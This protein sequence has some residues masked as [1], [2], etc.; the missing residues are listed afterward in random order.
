[1]LADVD[2]VEDILD[3]VGF[4][5][6]FNDYIIKL[7]PGGSWDIL[8]RKVKVLSKDLEQWVELELL[9][10]LWRTLSLKVSWLWG[11]PWTGLAPKL[12]VVN[13]TIISWRI[14]YTLCSGSWGVLL[15]RP[16]KTVTVLH[17]IKGLSK[18]LSLGQPGQRWSEGLEG[19]CSGV[20][21]LTE[22]AR[23]KALGHPIKVDLM[24]SGSP[25][26]S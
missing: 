9:Y 26:C 20:W 16:R 3:W 23:D 12:S 17:G 10:V 24:T 25:M 6:S 22:K 19:V 1:M 13:P 2:N 15:N 21:V 4:N 8:L 14:Y 7:C 5:N 18:V 11:L